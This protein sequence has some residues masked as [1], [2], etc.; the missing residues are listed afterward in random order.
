MEV[1]P[2]PKEKGAGSRG[3][4]EKRIDLRLMVVKKCKE[5]L[6]KGVAASK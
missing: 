5:E 4:S 2:A 6:E 1:A 3:T